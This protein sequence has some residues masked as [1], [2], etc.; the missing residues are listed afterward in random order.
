MSS[1]SHSSFH[2]FQHPQQGHNFWRVTNTKERNQ[3]SSKAKTKTNY[4]VLTFVLFVCVAIVLEF[5][6]MHISLTTNK[7]TIIIVSFT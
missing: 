7:E 3:T 5:C 1:L 2:D 6:S 4:K